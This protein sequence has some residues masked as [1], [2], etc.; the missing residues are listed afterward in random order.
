MTGEG[1]QTPHLEATRRYYDEFAA[2]Y[3]AHRGG[4]VPGGYHDLVD[5]LELGFLER[6]ATGM[7]V[8]EVGC[9][10]GL[11]LAR[12]ARFSRR[13]QGV[14]LSPNMLA[15]ARARGLDVVEGSATA[16]PFDDESFDVVC[17]FKVLA[18]VA[19]IEHALGEMLRVSRRWVVAE[20]YNRHSL[21]SVVKRLGP[22][23]AISD[24]TRESAVYT[25]YDTPSE[26]QRWLPSGSHIV[27]SRG[28]R[29]VT[30]VA[31]ALRL[32]LLRSAF[33]AA[34]RRLCDTSLSRFG[35]FW[36]AAIAKGPR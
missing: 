21:R 31:A 8:L 5:D 6:F 15:R 13:V 28:I 10:T 1:K 35:G 36:I 33:S 2:R 19:D 29:I 14:D 23:S 25:R 16:L 18:H 24:A 30:P 20:F 22:A 26:V 12:M 7:D 3:D 17:S 34:E 9:G 32:P 4:R 11:L 27:A